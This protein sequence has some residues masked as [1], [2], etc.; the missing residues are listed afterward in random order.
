[1]RLIKASIIAVAAVFL[2]AA[3]ALAVEC[4]TCK[5]KL[6]DG[7]KYCPADGT[8]LPLP[9]V[10]KPEP[11]K[12]EP[13]KPEPKKPE[14]K[15]VDPAVAKAR[16]ARAMLVAAEKAWK[17]DRKNYDAAIVRYQ[18]V[19]KA[20]A[21][22]RYEKSADKMIAKL[23]VLKAAAAKRAKTA[24]ARALY[25]MA[26]AD[27][28]KNP[29][30]YDAAIKA[31]GVAK[32]SGAGT[33]YDRK[34]AAMI[35]K[36]ERYKAK[37]VKKP[38]PKKPEPK[39][40][41]PKKPEPKKPEPK[42]VDSAVAKARQAKGMLVAAE[43][44]WKADRKNYDAAIVR[45]QEVKKAAAGTRYEKSAD[46]MIAKLKV[47]KAAAAKRAKTANARALYEMALADYKKNPK[48]YDAA[49]KAFGVAKKSGAGTG[50]D[51]KAAAMIAKVEKYK[52]KA[53]K[54]PEPKKPEP[55]KPE[56][57]KPEPKKPAVVP[58]RKFV[59]VKVGDVAAPGA[60][61]AKAQA[62]EKAAGKTARGRAEAALP[63]YYAAITMRTAD[64]SRG[65][66]A[67]AAVLRIG[68]LLE[69]FATEPAD[70]VDASTYYLVASHLD[71]D[72]GAWKKAEKLYLKAGQG[73]QFAKKLAGLAAK[74]KA[75]GKAKLAATLQ[76]RADELAKKHSK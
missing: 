40:P 59:S 30:D 16:Q 70:L 36:V 29:K 52:A 17:A 38:E 33:G 14:P 32:K 18:E 43:K 41:E 2:T 35:A 51:R 58:I 9:A 19:K 67:A 53:V 12:P 6:K 42:K 5:R 61:F 23:K 15:K 66:D 20:A 1:M 11:K 54:K 44:A 34:A 76:A 45:Y 10:K 47:L 57:K 74:A 4:P 37:A 69:K 26:L 64:G 75:D 60:A 46:K 48:D 73:A 50:Y 68:E 13:K 56:P 39:K 27:Y 49:I 63:Y 25:E 21:G 31:F 62:L 8:K 24:N 65:K 72:S 3:L 28:K 22:T 55:K 7:T 71:L